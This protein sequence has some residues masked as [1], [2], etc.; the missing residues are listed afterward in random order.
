MDKMI[1]LIVLIA[2]IIAACV[3]M[4]ILDS[5][6][7]YKKVYVP[8]PNKSKHDSYVSMF[9]ECYSKET[10]LQNTFRALIGQ[11]RLESRMN[12]DAAAFKLLNYYVKE[13]NVSI[14]E[15]SQYAK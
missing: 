9:E 7:K 13:F 4:L 10:N 5:K 2:F 15:C 6:N 11:K 3:I 14:N 12:N 8:N 1:I